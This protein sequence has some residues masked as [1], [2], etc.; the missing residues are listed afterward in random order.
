MPGGAHVQQVII[1]SKSPESPPD[2]PVDGA[3]LQVLVLLRDLTDGLTSGLGPVDVANL[4]LEGCLRHTAC[5]HAGIMLADPAGRL[6]VLASSS[7]GARN[8]ELLELQAHEGPCLD[9]YR[10]G[11]RVSSGDLSA[12][13]HRWPHFAV[14]AVEAGMHEVHSI[15][16]RL[17]DRTIGALNIFMGHGR[18]L[19]ETDLPFCEIL[20]GAATLGIVTRDRLTASAN[21][22]ASCR[23]PSIRAPSSSRPRVSSPPAPASTWA[24]R[25]NCS[26]RRRGT[27]DA[28]CAKWHR[29]LCSRR[30]R[31]PPEADATGG[32]CLLRNRPERA[33]VI[34]LPRPPAPR[35]RCV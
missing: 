4:L 8:L 23:P 19:A 31:C 12:D 6:H 26:G 1:V 32:M 20:A 28:R 24:A 17:G 22:P 29:R 11:R 33:K 35:E 7:E 2:P 30:A 15:P 13:A 16:M 3:D 14:A 10:L 21:S 25:S 5:H 34:P 27:S 18:S 9:A